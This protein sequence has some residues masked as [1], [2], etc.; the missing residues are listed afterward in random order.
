MRLR[1]KAAYR[2]G[3]ARTG[4]PWLGWRVQ[5]QGRRTTPAGRQVHVQ[6]R[7]QF[8][9]SEPHQTMTHSA[10]ASLS[11][12]RGEFAMITNL[13]RVLVLSLA[14]AIA[15]FA[16]PAHAHGTCKATA[17]PPVPGLLTVAHSGAYDCT[18]S[19]GN[20]YVHSCVQKSSSPLT[21][22][23]LVG[24]SSGHASN[25]RHV[26]AFGTLSDVCLVGFYR[27]YAYGHNGDYTHQHVD[28]SPPVA[29]LGAAS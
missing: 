12:E 3:A 18:E 29:C 22:W 19:H 15:G 16:A 21:G 17:A 28:Y 2:A 6:D 20:L 26:H 24:C 10:S 4:S 8:G 13:R 11:N 5:R 23:E 25:A 1:P 9:A 14:T 7:E 27:A